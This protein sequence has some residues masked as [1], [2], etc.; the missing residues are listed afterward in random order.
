MLP[1]CSAEV[2]VEIAYAAALLAVPDGPAKQAGI[3]LGQ[4]SAAANL[5]RRVGAEDDAA[6]GANLVVLRPDERGVFGRARRDHGAGGL[7]AAPRLP[8]EL[9]RAPGARRRGRA[10]EPTRRRS[11]HGSCPGS[12]RPG[13]R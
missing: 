12:G 6:Y 13:A 9:S 2:K 5:A 4:E 10:A 8:A 1:P 3:K 11:R 7:G